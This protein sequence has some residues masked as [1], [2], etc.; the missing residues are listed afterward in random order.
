MVN[1]QCQVE[2]ES[3][4]TQAKAEFMT[5]KAEAHSQV[6]KFEGKLG[7]LVH[8]NKQLQE[9]LIAQTNQVKCC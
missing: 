8:V 6:S 2:I 1:A 7:E 5:V 9:R 3:I 4:R